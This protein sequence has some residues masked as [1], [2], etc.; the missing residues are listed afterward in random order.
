MVT[1]P[2]EVDH[3]GDLT[4]RDRERFTLIYNIAVGMMNLHR[5]QI[6]HRDLNPSNVL[7]D[8]AFDPVISDFGFSKFS[9]VDQTPHPPE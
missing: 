7:L 3:P 1:E 6:I 2:V 9:E 8:D 4:I 5:R